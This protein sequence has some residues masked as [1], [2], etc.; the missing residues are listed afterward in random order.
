MEI[1]EGVGKIELQIYTWMNSYRKSIMDINTHFPVGNTS[2][3][4]ILPSVTFQVWCL[5]E[6]Y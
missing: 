5:K 6:R 1:G 3:K 4:M 2:Q